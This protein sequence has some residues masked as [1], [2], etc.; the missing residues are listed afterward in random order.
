MSVIETMP[1]TIPQRLA[2]NAE[3]PDCA[4]FLCL[5]H[6][7]G[8][9]ER[10]SYRDVL[11]EAGRYTSFYRQAGLVPGDRMV[12]I[13][14]HSLDAYASFIGAILG[15]FVPSFWSC[16][17]PKI[18]AHEYLKMLASL[19][20]GAKPRLLLT[21][22]RLGDQPEAL[23]MFRD[24]AVPSYVVDEVPK[25]TEAPAW[26]MPDDPETIAFLQYSSGTTGAKKGVAI[27]HRALLWQVDHYADAIRLDSSDRIVSWL[28]LYHDMGLIACFMLPFIR[29]VPLVAM[30][31][32]EWV[33]RPAMWLQAISDFRGT[34]SW[35]PN[36][37]YSF[38][39]TT[40]TD[41]ELAGIDL[42]SLR[43]IVNCSEPLLSRSH[44]QFVRRFA[45]CGLSNTALC[46][47]YAMAENTFAV[48][49]GGFDGP[50]A[51]D[52]IDGPTFAGTGQA[53]PAPAD[54][55]TCRRMIS[56][57]TP[58][59]QT[60]IT[61]VDDQGRP[62]PD[63][64]LGEIVLRTPCLLTRYDNNPEATAKALRDGAYFTGDLG[65]VADGQ[66]YVTG[67]KNDML[68]IRGQNI[69]P[70]DIEEIVS[71]TPGIIPGRC[72]AIGVPNE[73]SGTEDL[74]ILAETQET[75]PEKRESIRRDV[76]ARIARATEVA[77][78]DV[79]LLEHM[80]LRKST[81]G[82][83]SRNVNR[84]RYIEMIADS[85]SPESASCS[86]NAAT[87]AES[88]LSAVR[89]CVTQVLSQ[90]RAGRFA[91]VGDDE[92]LVTSGLIDSLGLV[93]LLTAVETGF[94]VQ[95]PTPI[96]ADVLNI[97]TIR[98]IADLVDRLRTGA[99]GPKDFD[100]FPHGP[101]DVPLLIGAPRTTRRTKG[102]WAHYYRWVFRRHGIRVGK[103]LRVLGP[104][105][106]R[107][108]G[109]PRNITIGEDVT[110]MPGVDLKIRENGSIILH[111]GVVLDTNVRLVAARDGR[112][113]LGENAQ[114]GMGTI[115]NAGADVIIGRR[116]AFAS[117]CT[118][119]SSEHN[120]LTREPFMRQ[121]YR[122]EPVYIGEDVWGAAYTFVGR[123]ARI[124]NGAVIGANTQI[125]GHIPAW[126][127]VMGNPARVVRFR[128]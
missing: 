23:T 109:D 19:L 41:T 38:M 37:A 75:D 121:G 15:G 27:S 80:W 14:R 59:P 74:I 62:L 67:R 56:S 98:R 127:V 123:G 106:L 102:F 79:C 96:L 53:I 36:F 107:F 61:I 88:T 50:L 30:C 90:V 44:E 104:L 84:D 122:H 5:L 114:L 43:G 49:S 77:P 58:L 86:P 78:A 95:I 65:Y 83:I 48:T 1:A 21:Y 87:T 94:R 54:S 125:R 110:L 60:E 103:G 126:A 40:V 111:D 115:V 99:P 25:T 113:I 55:P 85:R 51:D 119:I 93:S 39:A 13:L 16:P 64:R 128:T 8:E 9:P 26:H 28:P 20:A 89:R 10:F 18:S 108:D 57:G 35:L 45:A 68:I 63:R 17:S 47:S 34:L 29:Q 76:L 81:S 3:T 120:Y 70:Q 32:F 4:E 22:S 82:K 97:D 6:A 72:A 31:P 33:Q 73:R 112:I 46:S 24:A 42:S 2:K 69:Y 124:G 100:S 117:Y 7:D 91:R 71:A 52:C 66:L 116:T 105:M 12:I 118:I 92:P 101:D 11:N